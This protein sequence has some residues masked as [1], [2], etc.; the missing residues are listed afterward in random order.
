M[1]STI[2]SPS[3]SVTY[4]PEGPTKE[5]LNKQRRATV[6]I[7]LIVIVI[8]ALIIT[9]LVLLLHPNTPESYVA[10]I[11]DVFII[12]MAF[13]SLL[14]G[15]V[16]VIL[17]LQLARLTNLIQNEIKPILDSTN[18]TVSTLRGTTAFISNN[19]L[20]PIMK[21][22]EYLAGLMRLFEIIKL[23]KRK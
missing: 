17:I 16:L 15:S 11:R 14:I 2:T 7:S 12:I 20:E 3:D 9:A 19:L 21:L 13:E 23:G 18:E 10:R 22:N 4:T 8:L 1:E 6:I 5:Q